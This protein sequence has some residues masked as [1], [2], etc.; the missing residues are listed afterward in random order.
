MATRKIKDA[1]DLSTNELIYFKGHAKATYMSDGRN[2]EDAISQIGTGGGGGGGIAAETDPIFSASPAASI[3]EAKKTEWDAKQEKITDLDAIR[4]GAEKGATALQ[5]VPP[6]YVTETE[7]NNKGYATTSAL[8]NKVDKVS[9]KQLSTQDFTTELEGKLKGIEANAQ[10]NV[11]SDWNESD[12]DSDTY[13]NNRTHYSY[14]IEPV[15][16]FSVASKN[17]GDILVT[18]LHEGAFYRFYGSKSDSFHFVLGRKII[19]PAYG[20]TIEAICAYDDDLDEYCLKLTTPTY[21][22]TEEFDL[23]EIHVEQLDDVYIPETIA[24]KAEI[25][26]INGQSLTEGGDIT[27]QGGGGGDPLWYEDSEGRAYCDRDIHVDGN[28]STSSTFII[29]SIGVPAPEGGY[30]TGDSG[31]ILRADGNGMVEWDDLSIPTKVSQ[32]ENDNVYITDFKVVDF[33]HLKAGEIESLQIDPAAL[34]EAI[35]AKKT[36]LVPYNDGY[37]GGY[38]LLLG[39]VAGTEIYFSIYTHIGQ[40]IYAEAYDGV[41]IDDPFIIRDLQMESVRQLELDTLKNIAVANAVQ[42]DGLLY[43]FPDQATGDEDDVLLSRGTV[44]T[45]NG[46]TIMRDGD[47]DDIITTYER[48]TTNLSSVELLPNTIIEWPQ[49]ILSQELV[50]T[51]GGQPPQGYAVEYIAKF[52]VGADGV[53]L[54]VPDNV[55]WADGVYPAMTNGKTYEI[56]F[57]DNL[58]TFLEF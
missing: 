25:A 4:S 38:G 27:I 56:S 8:N 57:V 2:V 55:V 33:E 39:E 19:I 9:G 35:I 43:A 13:V 54:I 47:N 50:L 22:L 53:Q 26:T 45:I 30:R 17:E 49:P 28:I 31:Q 24:R 40:Y 16:S 21:G 1:K 32:L 29:G 15:A 7:L 42:T 23:M 51:F 44:K 36:I 18:G 10:K 37:V 58:A 12:T 3:T 48:I 34:S 52:N 46:K 11:Q 5:S 14:D 20:P 6:E 41:V